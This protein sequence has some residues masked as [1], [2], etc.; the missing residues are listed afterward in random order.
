MTSRNE[1]GAAPD[2]FMVGR[3]TLE[4]ALRELERVHYL[5]QARLL[6]E[7]CRLRRGPASP[8]RL[9]CWLRHCREE[10]ALAA[11]DGVEPPADLRACAVRALAAWP[12]A[13]ELARLSLELHDC[14]VG[15]RLSA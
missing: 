11:C 14:R 12:T 13:R 6:R 9:A 7:A 5:E 15:R 10:L 2:T 4:A 8:E 3:L 1:P